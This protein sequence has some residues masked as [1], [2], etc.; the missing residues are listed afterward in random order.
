MIPSIPKEKVEKSWRYSKVDR[1]TSWYERD[2]MCHYALWYRPIVALC[3]NDIYRVFC[4]NT[5]CWV[6]LNKVLISFCILYKAKGWQT[7]EFVRQGSL[8]KIKLKQRTQHSFMQAIPK[9][10]MENQQYTFLVYYFTFYNRFEIK[11]KNLS[12]LKD[13]APVK[14]TLDTLVMDREQVDRIVGSRHMC[15]ANKHTHTSW[16]NCRS[17][18]MLAVSR[19][20]KHK[21]LL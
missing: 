17:T 7:I 6:A 11:D 3:P 16:H 4:F 19:P 18:W 2:N 5:K 8:Y 9:V 15:Y 1:K 21:L 14:L 10:N 13:Y 20:L 12:C